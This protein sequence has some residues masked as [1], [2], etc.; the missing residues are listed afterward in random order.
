MR[1]E[2]KPKKQLS[3]KKETV[4]RVRH[5]PKPKKQL[6]KKRD[7]F[8]CEILAEAEE[9]ADYLKKRQFSV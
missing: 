5:E 9:T 1:Y 6:S 8:P 4:F 3:K 2:P 7:S